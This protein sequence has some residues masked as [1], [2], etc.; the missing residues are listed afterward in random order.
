MNFWNQ[1][2]NWWTNNMKV[3]FRLKTYEIFFGIQ[4]D[5][6]DPIIS[7]FNFILLMTRHF[8][9]KTK[10]ADNALHMYNLLV[11]CKNH[12]MLEENFMAARNKCNK[13][14]KNWQELFEN[15]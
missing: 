9:Y 4:N 12:L 7:Q 11:E 15:L 14:S 1:V 8:I 13:F 3:I 2:L 10:K 6:K 5:E